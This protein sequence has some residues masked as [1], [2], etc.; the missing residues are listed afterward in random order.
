MIRAWD[1]NVGGFVP[2]DHR[3]PDVILG[4]WRMQGNEWE[5]GEME[6]NAAEWAEAWAA[7]IR[8]VFFNARSLAECCA[9]FGL[10]CSAVKASRYDCMIGAK[11]LDACRSMGTNRWPKH[12]KVFGESW[13]EIF[14]REKSM[15]GHTAMEELLGSEVRGQMSEVR[16]A[17]LNAIMMASWRDVVTNKYAVSLMEAFKTFAS[18]AAQDSGS[19]GQVSQTEFALGFAQ[20]RAAFSARVARSV[21]QRLRSAG[22]LGTTVAGGKSATACRTYAAVQMGNTSKASASWNEEEKLAHMEALHGL[23]ED[24]GRMPVKAEFKGNAAKTRALL[25]ALHE[26]AERRR[27]GL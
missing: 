19:L 23:R 7:L 18:M 22:M 2:V 1:E 21:K 12:R 6:R 3:S 20:T 27:L 10:A 17:A 16:R 4:L 8:Y 11:Y 13:S 25:D 24:H 9:L 26:Q 14:D 15:M 5:A